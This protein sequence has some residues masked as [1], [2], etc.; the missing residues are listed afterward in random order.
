MIRKFSFF[1]I[2]FSILLAQNNEAIL[3]RI[4]KKYDALQ[5]F[6]GKMKVITD[7]PNFRM[8]VKTVHIFYKTPDKMKMKVKGFAILPKSG[9]L[10][11]MYLKKFESDSIQIDTSYTATVNSKLMTYVSI[12]DTSILKGAEILLTIDDY[13]E[14]IE[15]VLITSEKDT[16][17][18]IDFTYQNID[19]FWMPETTEFNFNL[20]KRLP[21]TSGP[22]ITNPFGSVDIG[23]VEDHVET[24]GKVSLIFQ[25]IKIN[26]GLED[27][28]FQQKD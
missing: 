27:A 18:T 20:K 26:S 12:A 2:L 8:P 14:R 4:S 15:S 17:S 25:E 3:S 6:Q 11:F 24:W 10:P 13:L 16:I 22:S 9:I 21:M 5:D 23:S 19:G 1:I 7:V 28:I